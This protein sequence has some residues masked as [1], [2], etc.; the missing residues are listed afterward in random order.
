VASCPK[1]LQPFIYGNYS[2]PRGRV[3]FEMSLVNL[4]QAKSSMS[5]ATA[6]KIA[7]QNGKNSEEHYV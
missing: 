5:H 4:R 7:I 6:K 3:F 2:G 1:S